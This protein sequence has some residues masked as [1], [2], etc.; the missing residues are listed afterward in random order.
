[1]FDQLL[2]RILAYSYRTHIGL[3]TVNSSANVSQPITHIVEDFRATVNR[4]EASGDTALWDSLELAKDQIVEY[5]AKY[6]AGKYNT[7]LDLKYTRR[8]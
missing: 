5:A 2:N 1:M 6:P 3:I 8:L 7:Y 4:L